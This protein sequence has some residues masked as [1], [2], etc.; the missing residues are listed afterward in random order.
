MYLIYLI[1]KS[2]P[3]DGHFSPRGF[4]HLYDRSIDFPLVQKLFVVLLD[5]ERSLPKDGLDLLVIEVLLLQNFD[6]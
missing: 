1:M 4:P 2:D 3:S 6:G 5:L